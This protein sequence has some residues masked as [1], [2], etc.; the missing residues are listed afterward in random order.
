M[1][2]AVAAGLAP[3]FW[4]A[5]AAKMLASAAVV[6][7]ASYAVERAGPLV[8]AMIA[9]LPL[10]AGPAYVF[11]ALDHPPDFLRESA[12]AS[13]PAIAATGL[14]ILAY[15]ALARRHGLAVSVCAALAVW[16]AAAALLRASVTGL[17]TGAAATTL[18]I[19]GCMA[20]ARSLR[21]AAAVPVRSGR[22]RDVLIRAGIVMLL[23]AAVMVAGRVAGP[24]LAGILAF[25]P[26]VMV[27]LAVILHPRLGGPASATVLVLSLPGLLGFVAALTALALTVERLGPALGLSL[28]LLINAGWNGTVLLI[29]RP[30]R[31]PVETRP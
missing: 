14:F 30:A 7:L 2:G 18:V 15:A 8:G 19:L 12:V 20:A 27:S 16:L 11:L 29:G 13:L 17:A 6:V 4:A 9:T 3:A 10:S 25:A 1:A 22:G 5:L 28:A 26:V 24:G 23:V 21:E 31:Q